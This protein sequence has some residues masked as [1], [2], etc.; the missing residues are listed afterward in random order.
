MSTDTKSTSFAAAHF[1]FTHGAAVNIIEVRGK[2]LTERKMISVEKYT[3]AF[4]SVTHAS[5]AKAELVRRGIS[6]EVIRTPASLSRGCGYSVTAEGKL[7]KI[8]EIFESIGL[9]YRAVT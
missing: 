6:A 8:K 1:S 5:K 7:E 4:P 3:F 2:P 9:H